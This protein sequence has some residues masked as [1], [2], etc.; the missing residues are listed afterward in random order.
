MKL[1]DDKNHFYGDALAIA[2]LK[3]GGKIA[4][5]WFGLQNM[6]NSD[7][8]LYDLFVALVDKSKTNQD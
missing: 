2:Q 1:L 7:E 8:L 3:S 6:T 5:C 4:Y